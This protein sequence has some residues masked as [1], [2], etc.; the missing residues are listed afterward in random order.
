ML[1]RPAKVS[2]LAV[3]GAEYRALL[4]LLIVSKFSW[5][6]AEG[7]MRSRLAKIDCE[8]VRVRLESYFIIMIIVCKHAFVCGCVHVQVF[9][10]DRS[11][12]CW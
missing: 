1:G 10:V 3:F 4:L 11:I 6:T 2:E 5:C 12:R 9:L 8:I 7:E